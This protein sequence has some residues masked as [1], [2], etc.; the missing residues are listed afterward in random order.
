MVFAAIIPQLALTANGLLTGTSATVEPSPTNNVVGSSGSLE[1]TRKP[2][3]KEVSTTSTPGEPDFDPIQIMCELNGY[4]LPAVVDTGA[5]LSIMSMSCAKRCRLSPFID[6]RYSGKAIG[7][8]FGEIVGQIRDIPLRIGPIVTNSRIA[9]LRGGGSSRV[10]FIIGLDLLRKF[11][12]DISLMEGFL[13]LHFKGKAFKIPLLKLGFP[14]GGGDGNALQQAADTDFVS[15]D[16]EDTAEPGQ[17]G[18]S[19]SNNETAVEG[20]EDGNVSLEGF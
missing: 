6:P 2:Q 12:C 13:R 8:G 18:D 14:D 5:Q 10:D 11:K 16:V 9:V 7:V 15:K 4:T 1:R 20:G 19:G 17:H 3:E